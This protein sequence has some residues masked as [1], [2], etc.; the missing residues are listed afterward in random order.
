MLNSVVLHMSLYLHYFTLAN[1]FNLPTKQKISILIIFARYSVRCVKAR[2][3]GD[4]LRAASARG[5]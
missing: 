5:K 2:C 3:N 4:S 1:L